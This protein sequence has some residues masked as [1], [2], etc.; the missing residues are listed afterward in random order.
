MTVLS[1]NAF[2]D[3]ANRNRI[4]RMHGSLGAV[5][6]AAVLPLMIAACGNDD[7]SDVAKDTIAASPSAT[8]P[9][10]ANVDTAAKATPLDSSGLPIDKSVTRVTDPAGVVAA[11]QD[12]YKTMGGM[13]GVKIRITDAG[14]IVLEGTV[15]TSDRK[16]TAEDVARV[17][18][19]DVP[20]ENRLQIR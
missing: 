7:A 6:L 4:R 20:V 10:S 8:A 18:A 3:A 9:V 2:R 12:R 14:G 16:Q 13:N 11:M 19:G 15:P 17:I 1:V 5:M